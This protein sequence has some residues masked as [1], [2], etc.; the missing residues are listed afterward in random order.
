MARCWDTCERCG[1]IVIISNWDG[2]LV[3]APCRTAE[4]LESLPEATE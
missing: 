3:C 2:R 1:F 4:Y